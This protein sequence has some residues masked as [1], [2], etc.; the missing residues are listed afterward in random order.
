M[1]QPSGRQAAEG[2]IKMSGVREF[3]G[4]AEVGL[5]QWTCRGEDGWR[6]R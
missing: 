1:S 6:S 4:C 3:L 2:Y 5:A